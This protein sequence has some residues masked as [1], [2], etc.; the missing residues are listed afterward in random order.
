M[1]SGRYLALITLLIIALARTVGAVDGIVNGT[2]VLDRSIPLRFSLMSQI[3][4]IIENN[5]TTP[6]TED[7]D[8]GDTIFRAY[9]EVAGRVSRD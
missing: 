2:S 8:V 7:V 1:G 6:A 4:N 9:A 5:E 3:T